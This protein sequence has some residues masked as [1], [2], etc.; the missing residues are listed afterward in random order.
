MQYQQL[1]PTNCGSWV[2]ATFNFGKKKKYIEVNPTDE[3]EFFP[4]DKQEKYIPS[5][6]DIAL[7]L[8]VADCNT[9][10]Y[11]ETMRET[12]G[13][14]SEI[15][16]LAWDDVDLERRHVV[17]YTR[18]KKRGDRTPRRV[19][20]TNRLHEI[21]TR[22]H[23]RRDSSKPWVFWHE[24]ISSKTKEP[25]VGPFQDRKRIMRKLCNAAGVKYFRFHALRHAGASLMDAANVPIGSIQ[26]ILGHEHRKTTEIYLHGMTD[27]ERDA[28]DVFERART[29][30]HT[31]SHT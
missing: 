1:S 12:L 9:R 25:Y 26:R 3:T 21:L 23:T 2:S 19:P 13:R 15:N 17:L 22:R 6:W 27:A 31:E 29:N 10:D 20:M 30:S 24:C 16:N 11:L 14:M 4:V 8:E 18:K 28:M 7:V 5:L